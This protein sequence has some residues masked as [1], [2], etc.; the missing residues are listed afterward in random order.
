[1][2]MK[3]FATLAVFLSTVLLSAGVCSAKEWHGIV[4]LKSNRSDVE[5]LLGHGSD[6]LYRYGNENVLVEYS[7]FPCWHKSPPGW[8]E[9]PP[10]WNVPPDTVVAIRVLVGKQTVP[11]NSLGYDLS[12]LKK[13]RED[14]DLM[15][16]FYYIDEAAGF[17][18]E[19]FDLGNEQKFVRAFLYTP[20]SKDEGLFRCKSK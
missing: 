15:G 14:S 3:I 20:T 9:A 18:I 8:P 12:K 19:C 2:L 11:L 17:V 16:Q 5:R 7:Q 10:G 6:N 13:V 4:P 1:M